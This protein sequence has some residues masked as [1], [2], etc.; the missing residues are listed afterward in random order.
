[1]PTMADSLVLLAALSYLVIAITET[2]GPANLFARAREL[3]FVGK[4]FECPICASIW[5]ALIVLGI[6]PYVPFLV[7]AL[8]LA[9]VFVVL[10]RIWERATAERKLRYERERLEGAEELL[11]TILALGEEELA[12]LIVRHYLGGM[13]LTTAVFMGL[14]DEKQESAELG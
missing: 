12:R 6:Y 9:G 5:L 11:S 4:L 3:R 1:M 8:A 14:R 10:G 13:D 2:D 7:Y